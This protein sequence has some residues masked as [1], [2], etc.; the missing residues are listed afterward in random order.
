MVYGK[1]HPLSVRVGGITLST[2]R[3]FRLFADT[4]IQGGLCLRVVFYWVLCQ[5]SLVTVMLFGAALSGVVGSHGGLGNIWQII[6][7]A[8]VVSLLVLPIAMFDMLVYSNKFAGPLLRFRRNFGELAR[9]E[10]VRQIH[11]RPG[12]LLNDLSENYNTLVELKNAAEQPIAGDESDEP[13]A[14]R[15]DE[16]SAVLC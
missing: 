5:V 13:V 8:V 6:G 12:D 3:R 1:N 16:E 15:R 11:F 9:G 14:E 4:R 7:P 10:E 2:Q